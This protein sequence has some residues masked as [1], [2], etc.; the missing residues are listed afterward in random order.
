MAEK[1]KQGGSCGRLLCSCH[2]ANWHSAAEGCWVCEGCAAD[3]N[4]R[5]WRNRPD[6]SP[7]CRMDV[8]E[9]LPDPVPIM[10]YYEDPCDNVWP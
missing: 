9:L 4:R 5:E 2:P 8:T 1:G 6:G 7:C 3:E 10:G